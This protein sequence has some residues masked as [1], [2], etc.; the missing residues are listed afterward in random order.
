[1]KS[2]LTKK[3]DLENV[4]RIANGWEVQNGNM[5]YMDVDLV[6]ATACG[7]LSTYTKNIKDEGVLDYMKSLKSDFKRTKESV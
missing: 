4:D 5:V 3:Y 1:M 6:C 2:I 7:N